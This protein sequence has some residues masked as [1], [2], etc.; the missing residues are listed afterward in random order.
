MSGNERAQVSTI[1]E[2]STVQFSNRLK[3]KPGRELDGVVPHL[4]TRRELTVLSPKNN[5]IMQ[6][7]YAL[8]SIPEVLADTNLRAMLQIR[9]AFNKTYLRSNRR[10]II[11]VLRTVKEVTESHLRCNNFKSLTISS[12]S[13]TLIRKT[14]MSL[15]F[16]SESTHGEQ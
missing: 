12:W 6:L 13:S 1:K 9:Y 8:W 2:F 11:I 14:R 5:M 16:T 7:Q 4:G 3:T 15:Q 10:Q